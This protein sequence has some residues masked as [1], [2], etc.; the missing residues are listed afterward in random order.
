MVRECSHLLSVAYFLFQTA[1]IRL[2]RS[3]WSRSRADNRSAFFA[4]ENEGLVSA[5]GMARH[6]TKAH[7]IELP[8]W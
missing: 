4:G 2:R 1:G 3:Q 6:A 7:K 5:P 8:G